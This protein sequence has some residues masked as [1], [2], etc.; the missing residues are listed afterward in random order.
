MKSDLRRCEDCNTCNI[1]Y[2]I[3]SLTD[4]ITITTT[5]TAH[6]SISKCISINLSQL[7]MCI[8]F[9]IIIILLPT[10]SLIHFFLQLLIIH[11]NNSFQLYCVIFLFLLKIFRKFCHT[12][13]LILWRG[14]VCEFST[15]QKTSL[16][17]DNECETEC[18]DNGKITFFSFG[19]IKVQHTTRSECERIEKELLRETFYAERERI[20]RERENLMEYDGM[21]N[22]KIIIVVTE[23]L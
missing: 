14:I 11:F 12:H 16:K 5:D 22:I 13:S 15:R 19:N 20:F 17:P 18:E 10:S 8:T 2:I 4:I 1:Q 6:L 3:Y 23:W 7:V 9:F 21:W